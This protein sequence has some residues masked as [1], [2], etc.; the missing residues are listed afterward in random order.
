MDGGKEER[1]EGERGRKREGKVACLGLGG[2]CGL[3]E[4]HVGE[5]PRGPLHH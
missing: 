1:E 4:V 3:A 2:S 5:I